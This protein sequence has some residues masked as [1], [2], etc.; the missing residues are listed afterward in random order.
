MKLSHRKKLAH[1][2]AGSARVIWRHHRQ[3]CRAVRQG[4]TTEQV[5][6]LRVRSLVGRTLDLLAAP[7]RRLREAGAA[8]TALLWGRI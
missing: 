7:F 4:E 3:C 1:K 8:Q 2:R 5:E 6:A